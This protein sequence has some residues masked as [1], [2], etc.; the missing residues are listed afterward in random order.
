MLNE[1]SDNVDPL[2]YFCLCIFACSLLLGFY[3]LIYDN[4]HSNI[5]MLIANT[6]GIDAA[7]IYEEEK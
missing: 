3:I 5:L 2:F 4:S 1:K 7:K 6:N